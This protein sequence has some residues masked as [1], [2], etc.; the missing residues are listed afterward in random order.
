MIKRV[1]FT[2]LAILALLILV[3][4]V[5]P[6]RYA[7]SRTVQIQAP[8]EAIFPLIAELRN[9][10]QWEPFLR[11]DPGSVT[12]YGGLT[13]GVGA[14]QSWTGGQ[15]R[16]RLTFTVF[17]PQVGIEYD[18]VFTNGEHD[19]PGHSWM[20]LAPQTDGSVTLE[21]GIRGEMNV[22]VIG[23]YVAL[24]AD[25]PIGSRLERGLGEIKGLAEAGH[26]PPK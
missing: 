3:G 20:R 12:T 24:F 16:G 17:E 13:T 14:S 5:L 19:S 11:D 4:L 6:Q 1:L 2:V 22:P 18:L 10:P 7:T 26:A 15:N 23:G 21:W 25:K 8:A 9:W